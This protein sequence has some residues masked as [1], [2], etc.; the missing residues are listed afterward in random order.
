M[1]IIERMNFIIL[2]VFKIIMLA[3]VKLVQVHSPELV[4]IATLG[5]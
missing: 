4:L 2:I 1:P 5:K 3:L